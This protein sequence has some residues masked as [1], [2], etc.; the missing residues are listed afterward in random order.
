MGDWAPCKSPVLEK[1]FTLPV[2]PTLLL[3]VRGQ[4]Q[5][6]VRITLKGCKDE[7]FLTGRNMDRSETPVAHCNIQSW[8]L[9]GISKST[10]A[11]E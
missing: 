7:Q 6:M 8:F 11:W 10:Q 3:V 5:V 2:W 4:G 9:A 1:G